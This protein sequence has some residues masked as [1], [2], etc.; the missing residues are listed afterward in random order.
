[1]GWC[2][3]RGARAARYGALSALVLVT[4]PVPVAAAHTG[5]QRAAPAVDS[6]VTRPPRQVQMQFGRPAIPDGRTVVSVRGPDGRDLAAGEALAS[7]MG[8]SQP[9]SPLTAAGRYRVGYVVVSVD[10][11]L[12]RGEYAFVY[13]RPAA[14][15]GPPTLW[16]VA[17]GG[18][19][20]AAVAVVVLR[21][22][23]TPE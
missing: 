17:A 21:R 22:R 5:L 19:A 12:T 14:S 16:L 6:V 9:L 23:S 15:H 11:H 7:G 3:R 1:M 18:S 10:G 4:S 8:V 20:L 2:R 13:A